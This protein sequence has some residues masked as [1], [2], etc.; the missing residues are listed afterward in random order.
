MTATAQRPEQSEQARPAVSRGRAGA[1]A[2]AALATA[3]VLWGGYSH[4]WPWTGINGHTATLWDWLNLLLL[5]VAVGILPILVSRRTALQRRH[6]FVSASLLGCFVVLVVAGYAVP[7]AWTGFTGNKLWD[8]LSLLALPVAVALIPTFDEL[9]RVWS[10]RHSA[11]AAVVL[12]VFGAI[13]L[14]GYAGNWSWTGFRGNTLWDWMH[15]LLLPLLLP[16]VI[17]PAVRPVATSSLIA[18]EEANTSPPVAAASG[19]RPEAGPLA[20]AAHPESPEQG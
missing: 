10:K 12:T 9:Q 15:L 16:T 20:P 5:P 4:R 18:K 3:V 2:I 1:A 11:I 14:G 8:W 17:V 7:W 19:Q 6:K 13:I